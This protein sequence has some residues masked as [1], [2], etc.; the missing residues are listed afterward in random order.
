MASEVSRKILRCHAHFWSPRP[1][2]TWSRILLCTCAMSLRKWFVPI[3][4]AESSSGTEEKEL[5][6]IIKAT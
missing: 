6:S 4:K 2:R 5:V 3:S 1:L